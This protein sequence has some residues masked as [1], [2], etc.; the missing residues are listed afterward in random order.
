[1]AQLKAAKAG[2]ILAGKALKSLS[3]DHKIIRIEEKF[4]DVT[5][6]NHQNGNNATTEVNINKINTNNVEYNNKPKPLRLKLNNKNKA[7]NNRSSDE[8]CQQIEN[9]CICVIIYTIF[10]VYYKYISIYI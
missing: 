7:K 9:V 10:Y 6:S 4:D 5:Q 2:K 8:I 3:V 1:M